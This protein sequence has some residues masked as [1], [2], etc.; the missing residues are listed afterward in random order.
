MITELRFIEPW[1]IFSSFAELP[2]A[3]MLESTYLH[4]KLASFSYIGVFPEFILIQE[5]KDEVKLVEK[6]NTEIIKSTNIFQELKNIIKQ[7]NKVSNP[8]GINFI[9]GGIGY[10]GYDLAS[11]IEERLNL[12]SKKNP[13]LPYS[14][15]AFYDTVLAFD[16][17]LKKTYIINFSPFERYSFIKQKKSKEKEAKI[18]SLVNPSPKPLNIKDDFNIAC[19]LSNFSNFTKDEYIKAV[20]KALEYIYAGD[21]YQVNLSQRFCID[22]PNNNPYELYLRL[23]K[24][25]PGYFAGYLNFKDFIILSSSPE[26]FLY[27]KNNRVQTRPIKGTIKRGNSWIKDKINKKRLLRSQKDK[28]EL[29]MITDLLRNDLGKVCKYRTIKVKRLREIEKHKTV[30]HTVATIEGEL[31]EGKDLID[32]ILATF[33]GGSITGCPKIRS[34][35]IIDAL[36]RISRGIYTGS[37]GYISFSNIMDMNIII[38]T[39]LLKE[40]RLYLSAGGGIVADSNPQAEYYETLYK[41]SGLFNSLG[42]K[43]SLPDT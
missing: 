43:I 27:V 38:R 41:A 28:A 29:L 5:K 24:T 6:N 33:P 10:F 17:F 31:E 32:L 26:R 42:Y 14:V 1:K 34:M 39:F 36:E 19:V 22:Y 40:K 15:F 35:E 21:I 18:L 12:S 11:I 2:Y 16:H 7:Y 37:L 23:R 3:C 20:N 9:G 4:P 13:A 8:S 30:F 25:N